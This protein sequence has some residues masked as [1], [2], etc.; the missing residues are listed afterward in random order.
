MTIRELIKKLKENKIDVALDGNDLEINFDGDE[1][2]EDLIDEIRNNKTGIIQFLKEIHGVPEESIPALPQQDSY[3]VSSAQQRLWLLSQL[4]EAN[5]A[6][7]N[8]GVYAFVGSLDIPAFKRALDALVERHEIMRTVLRE[9]AATGELRQLVLPLSEIGFGMLSKDLRSAP[10]PEAAAR[11]L[12]FDSAMQPMNLATGPLLKAEMYQVADKKWVFHYVIHH[13]I[14]DGW[15]GGIFSQDLFTLYNLF[16]NGQPNLLPP[17]RIHYKDYAAWQKAQLSGEQLEQHR[18]YWLKQ[19]EGDL[20]LLDLPGD[21]PRPVLKTYNGATVSKNISA[22]VTKGIKALTQEQGGT[23]FMGLLSAV[24]I[25][26]HRYTGQQDIIVGFPVAGR[27]HP[28]LANQIGFYINTLTLRARFQSTDSFRQLLGNIKQVT[29][30][31]YEHQVYPFDD[32]LLNLN[33]QRDISRSPVFD[34]VVVLHNATGAKDGEAGTANSSGA[35]AASP[36]EGADMSDAFGVTTFDG[37]ENVISKYDLNFDFGEVGDAMF[38]RIEYNTDIYNR[39]TIQQ[40][41]DHLEQILTEVVASPDQ[42]INQLDILSSAQKQQLLGEFNPTAVAYPKEKTV[43]ELFDEQV[44]KTPDAI[45]LEFEGTI[46]SYAQLNERANRLAHY[47][48]QNHQAQVGDRIGLLLDRSDNLMVAILAIL[49][50]GAAYVPID[51]EYPKARQAFIVED[52]RI[53]VLITQ[54]DY[55]FG[56]DFFTGPMI[57]LDVQLEDMESPKEPIVSAADSES[58]IYIMFTSGSTGMPKGVIVPNRAAVRLVKNTNIIPLTGQE[59]IL[60]TGTVSFDAT[61][62][63]FW[64]ALLNGGRLV[65]CRKETLLDDARLAAAIQHHRVDMMWFTAGWLHQLID[66]SPDV[67][68]GLKVVLAGGDR[69]SP[70][71][72]AKLK[73][74]HPS[75]SVINGY[76]PTENTTFSLTYRIDGAVGD[77]IP[78]GRP[79]NN[80]TVYI[81]DPEERLLPVGVIGEICVGGDGLAIGYLNQPELTAEKFVDNPYRPGERMYKTGDLGRWLPNGTVEFVKRKDDQVKVRGYRIELGEIEA[82]LQQHPAVEAA[83]VIARPN[84][85]GEKEVV[86]YLVNKAPLNVTDLRAYLGNT[87]P[88]Y[89]IPAHFVEL[90]ALPLG[91]TGKVDKKALPDPLATSMG[92]GVEY[93]A[94]R[95]EKETVLVEI[96]QEVLKKEKVGALDDFFVLGGD[97]IKSIQVVARLKQKGYALTIQDV[98]LCPV[99][100]HLAG[101]LTI[102]ARQASQETVEGTIPLSPIQ[103]A[104]LENPYASKHHYNQPIFLNC[105]GTVSEKDLRAA[106]DKLVLHHDALRMVYY[107]TADGWVQENK[108]A[109]QGYGF[110]VVERIGDEQFLADCERIQASIDLTNGPLLK[111]ALFRRPQGDQL[112]L[113]AHHLVVDAVSWRIIMEDLGALYQQSIQGEPLTLPMKTDSLKYW[114]DKQIAYTQGEEVKQA[115][116]YWDSVEAMGMQAL[117]MD[118]EKGSN[119]FDDGAMMSIALDETATDKLLNQCF[120]AYRTEVNDILIAAFGMAVADVF[121][122]GK[123]TIALE[124]HG[125]ESLGGGEDIT[126]TVGWFTSIYPVTLDMQYRT[127]KIRQLI[128]VKETLH[129]VP[130]KGMDYGILR[131]LLKKDYRL[132]PQIVFNYLGDFG[133]GVQT[134]QGQAL[135]DFSAEYHGRFNAP[136]MQRPYVLEMNAMIVGGK[137]NINIAYSKLQYQPATIERLM[138]TAVQHLGYLIAQLSAE[139]EAKSTPVDFAY[140]GLSM[141]DLDKLNKMLGN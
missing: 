98:L 94:P 87:L 124:G 64:A 104:F 10:D 56:A 50:C 12:M 85:G 110:E 93:V 88:A 100:E 99:I 44:A 92:T 114:M 101:R 5:I 61:T 117:P 125:R 81:L 46:L 67:F 23:L 19:L 22:A 4:E 134:E 20:P 11:K 128:E 51:T 136:D 74:L 39:G 15:S 103:R 86:A 79:I 112:L 75:I 52:T 90:D 105:N 89:M 118:D 116:A 9:D 113:V 130:Q 111:V 126:R 37:N 60:P 140:Q 133:S 97:S 78:I 63:E 62:F 6:Y 69:L 42:P 132:D 48:R 95:N 14:S 59:T 18:S 26:L 96:Y 2:P 108:G 139:E 35:A 70:P 13:I 115:Q 138:N 28:D 47:L 141:E 7:N 84:T 55:L 16:I 80:S 77:N 36:V 131:H 68:T 25:L 129:R 66:K 102:A 123:I 73:Q 121:D 120:K 72:I 71:H 127:D 43:S 8:T 137:M 65:L 32:L 38:S 31:G 17:L 29:L 57:A 3:A 33:L 27:D 82:A 91:P 76:G 54:T 24:N 41:I 30:G 40:M 122:L 135:F 107:P 119:T 53:K 21:R 1:L 83:V 58:P 106:L 34:T 45:A 49:K 109:Q